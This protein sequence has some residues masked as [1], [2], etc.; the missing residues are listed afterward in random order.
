MTRDAILQKVTALLRDII[1]DESVVVDDATTAADVPG[2]DSFNNIN[3]M[4]AIEKAIGVRFRT[5]E[6]ESMRNVGELL[7]LIQQK[8]V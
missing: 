5:H 3:L 7:D 4:V 2:W 8:L 6:I 1:D